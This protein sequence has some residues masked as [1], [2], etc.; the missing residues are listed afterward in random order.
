MSLTARYAL[1][2]APD[3]SSSQQLQA[4]IEQ[5]ASTYAGPIFPPHLTLLGWVQGDEQELSDKVQSLASR[6]APINGKVTGFAGAPYYFRCFF[7]PLESSSELRQAVSDAAQ[8]FDTSAGSNYLA[9][10]SLLYGQ[11]DREEKKRI[12]SQIGEK[13]PVRFLL[14]KLQLIR[15]SVSVPGW[16]TVAEFPLNGA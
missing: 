15:M 16:T 7:A 13:V 8:E 11:L 4:V 10:I 1:W 14:N 3:D 5:L 6:L 9:H 2:L 12:P